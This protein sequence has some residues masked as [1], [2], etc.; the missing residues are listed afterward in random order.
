[1]KEILEVNKSKDEK[2]RPFLRWAGGKNWFVKHLPKILNGINYNNYHEP[3]LG[4]GSIFF[5][6]KPPNGSF[7]SDL[8]GELITT[9]N[10]LKEDPKAVI[11]ILSD[12]KNTKSFY[13][14][15][16]DAR[17]TNESKVAA[18]FI[19]LNQTSFNGIYRVNLEGKYNVPYGF[20]T[21]AFYEEENL[22]AVSNALK[23]ASLEVADFEVVLDSLKSRDL[24]FLDP[25]YTVSHNNNG[26]IKYNQ[27]LFSLDDQY[28]L[29]SLIEKIKSKGAYFILTNAAHKTIKGIFGTSGTL[30]K[31]NRA[32]LIGGLNASRGETSEYVF[33][34]LK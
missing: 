14:D 10:A 30:I 3:F 22:L 19:Y 12:F 24:V 32:S 29:F 26:F 16:R 17:Y 23:K 20:R 1:M 11:K 33:T 31:M 2:A 9:Y 6:L 4:G 28:R 27:K 8:N 34:N 18:R 7:L 21:K 5:H 25:P 13:Y 15:L